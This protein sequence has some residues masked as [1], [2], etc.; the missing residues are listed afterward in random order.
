MFSS[1]G[2]VELQIRSCS[3]RQVSN[4]KIP[5]ANKVSRAIRLHTLQITALVIVVVFIF[6]EAMAD[7][8][9]ERQSFGSTS[10]GEPIDLFKMVNRS[11]MEV[12]ITNYG[13]TIVSLKTRDRN[14]NLGDV[15]L[16][17][18]TLEGYESG[19]SYFG[20]TIGR[21][22][23][24]IAQGH[25]RLNGKDYSLPRNNYGNTLHGGVRGF[26]KRVW[27]A[28]DIS[29]ASELSLEMRY[30]AKDGEEG[31]PGNLNVTVVFTLPLN[32]NQLRIEYT[33]STDAPTIVNLTNHSYFNLSGEGVGNVLD[34]QLTVFSSKLTPV[35]GSLIP[36]GEIRS[37]KNTPFDFTKPASIGSRID[38]KNEQLKFGR[39]YDHNWVLSGKRHPMAKA[40]TLYDPKSGRTL[41]IMTTEP[42]IQFYSGNFLDGSIR[43]KDGK[44]YAYRSALCL[45]TQHFPDSPNHPSF[46]S[47]VLKPAETFHSTTVYRF[48]AR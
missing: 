34:H 26:N 39:G 9:I 47:V 2:G 5:L 21:Y 46:P 7:A 4:A 36:T 19:N 42:G 3:L 43:G 40:A 12:A 22:A 44:S 31:F 38:D 48:S 1:V 29:S 27:R 41:Q 14:G 11:G 8:K 35:D 37:I 6:I 25:F 18:D 10:Q 15:V 28:R 32:R 20:A 13:A 16:G 17:Y 33:A 23:N 45:E 30:A 24:R